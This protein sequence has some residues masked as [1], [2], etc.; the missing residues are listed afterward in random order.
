MDLS[1]LT[2]GERIVELARLA[3]AVH[4]DQVLRG[5][6]CLKNGA[7]GGEREVAASGRRRDELADEASSTFD[8]HSRW[9]SR[10]R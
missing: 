2:L 6:G 3:T 10:M 8:S 5:E 9:N 1:S 7:M 4:L